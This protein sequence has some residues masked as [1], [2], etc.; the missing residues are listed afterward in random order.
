MNFSNV[1]GL[2][3]IQ[4]QGIAT[5]ADDDMKTK[6][7]SLALYIDRQ[8]ISKAS[9]GPERMSVVGCSERSNNGVESFHASL[10]R[11]VMV[12]HPNIY[13]FITHLQ[14]VSI[15]NTADVARIQRGLSIRRPKKKFALTN[16]K[17][18]KQSMERFTAGQYT[19]YA[20]LSTVSH[21]AEN[22]PETYME[23][24]EVTDDESNDG[25]ANES[26]QPTES[27]STSTIEAT[28][29]ERTS[30]SEERQ[31]TCEVCLIQSTDPV[32]LVPCGHARF[33]RR[34]ADELNR[35][36]QRCPLC[37]ADITLVMHLYN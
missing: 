21:A 30:S 10:R 2:H 37:R 8:W 15:D 13:T 16:D 24:V 22:L 20:F 28:N 26:E 17:R 33:C 4:M 35:L 36:G 23:D 27:Q 29:P 1:T 18:I 14:N 6:L 11:R 7:T 25:A 5:I 34:C 12:A 32:A 31:R 19:R 3:D 9:I